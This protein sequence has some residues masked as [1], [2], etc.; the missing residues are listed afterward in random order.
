MQQHIR[1][2]PHLRNASGRRRDLLMIHCL[3]GVNDRNVR[4]DIAN[5]LF[6]DFKARL[7]QQQKIIREVSQSVCPELDLPQRLFSGNIEHFTPVGR[8]QPAHL[9]QQRRFTD[10]G[11]ASHQRQRAGHDTAAQHSVQFRYTGLHTVFFLY[12]H[13]RQIRRLHRSHTA[14]A[15]AASDAAGCAVM[16]DDRLLLHH[17]VPLFAGGTLS[18]PLRGFMSA[19][20]TVKHCPCLALSHSSQ[21]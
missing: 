13:L 16:P 4:H 9:Q 3:Y 15:A 12:A 2:F 21:S 10:S 17:T 11:I 14:C 7:T 1:G 5:R 8:H 18:H 6:H 19:V 20:L